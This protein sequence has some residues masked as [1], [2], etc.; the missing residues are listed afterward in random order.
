[1][2]MQ[3]PTIL[4]FCF[5]FSRQTYT[6]SWLQA[7]YGPAARNKT[8]VVMRLWKNNS[9]T[10][11]RNEAEFPLLLRSGFSFQLHH[12]LKCFISL[13]PQ[14]SFTFYSSE[15]LVTLDAVKR[16][17]DKFAPVITVTVCW[18]WR[19]LTLMLNILMFNVL[20]LNKFKNMNDCT[21]QHKLF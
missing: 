17:W 8:H 10:K 19:L 1:M 7:V 3:S 16:P 15:P 5:P 2:K 9:T 6:K 14:E 12:G 11:Q 21:F 13:A 20:M 4:S 18:H